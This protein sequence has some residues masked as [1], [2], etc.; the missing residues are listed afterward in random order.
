MSINRWMDK[1]Y[2]VY[3]FNGMLYSPKMKF[4]HMLQDEQA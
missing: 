2:V 4:W 1:K 3:T